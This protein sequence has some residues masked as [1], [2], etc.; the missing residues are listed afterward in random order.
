MLYQSSM[1]FQ[2]LCAFVIFLINQ[3]FHQRIKTYTVKPK[4]ILNLLNL[5]DWF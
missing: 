5:N 2:T 1:L 3:A 4:N